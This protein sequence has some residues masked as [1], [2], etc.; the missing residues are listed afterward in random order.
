MSLN[1]Q[2][3]AI[4]SSTS[5]NVVSNEV[6]NDID[7]NL[8]DSFDLESLINTHFENDPV[9]A[10]PTLEHKLG[11]PYEQV[12]K[13]IP[14]NGRKVIQNLRASY[15]KK[16][17]ELA[18]ERKELES[19]REK[20][21]NQQRLMTDSNFA[22]S[23]KELA[24][25]TTEHDIWDEN[26]RRSAIKK[27]AALMMQEMLK[28]LQEEVVA[29]RRALELERFKSNHP[30]LPE[31]RLDIAKLLMERKELKLEDAYYIA[32]AKKEAMKS[33][34]EKAL[35]EAKRGERREALYK[36]SAG[37]AVDTGN[38]SKPQFK[39]AWSAFQ[40]HKQHGSKGGR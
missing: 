18:A 15:T 39:D 28:P 3:T 27:E 20:F 14:E 6:V 22:K 12:L 2:E 13:H 7:S 25:D 32:K 10:E 17:Q 23:I 4:N 5:E 30:D 1:N 11:I 9:M 16:T 33:E 37:K 38:L 34:E 29:E 31:L 36:T 19:L 35:S 26:G 40:W 24:S 8:V 21:N